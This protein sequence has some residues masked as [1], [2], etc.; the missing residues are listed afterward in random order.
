M[1]SHHFT[2]IRLRKIS[3][4]FSWTTSGWILVATVMENFPFHRE[5]WSCAP[6]KKCRSDEYVDCKAL[7]YTEPG[8]NVE[9]S[10]LYENWYDHVDVDVFISH[11]LLLWLLD[12]FHVL[13]SALQDDRIVN[14]VEASARIKRTCYGH[15]RLWCNT[16]RNSYPISRFAKEWRNDV[17]LLFVV[18]HIGS[19]RT[20]GWQQRG[21]LP[22]IHPV[23]RWGVLERRFR[24]SRRCSDAVGDCG[25]CIHV[26]FNFTYSGGH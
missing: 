18:L 7:D 1:A 14:N 13:F 2:E 26:C 21:L 16:N 9:V 3:S 25:R 5:Y 15:H 20:H 12:R 17:G 23:V 6:V 10:S 24:S 4:W 11:G 19:I 8:V 22:F